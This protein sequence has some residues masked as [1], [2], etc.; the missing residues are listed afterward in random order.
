MNQIR[1]LRESAGLTQEQAAERCDLNRHT[2]GAYERGE[3]TPNY[4]IMDRIREE[5]GGELPGLPDRVRKVEVRL[6]S[7][8]RGA[9]RKGSETLFLDERFLLGT[10][11]ESDEL[12]Y[13]R[14]LGS[15]LEPAVSHR[16]IAGVEPADEIAGDDL[17]VYRCGASG[18]LVVGILSPQTDGI[19][20]E[21]R[22][23][24]PS[25]EFFEHVEGATYRD[26]QGRKSEL[27]LV[28]R[29]VAALGSPSEQLA[30][31]NE[32]ARTAQLS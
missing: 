1:E 32:A 10:G 25:T 2:F 19:V 13:V 26:E 11:L 27:T 8:G 23:P 24:H 3:R 22:G 20:I 21:T 30:K 12:I 31:V 15:G 29:V 7:A 16:Q 5:L 9:T 4:K 6:A 17:Y 14:V 18:G 28:G